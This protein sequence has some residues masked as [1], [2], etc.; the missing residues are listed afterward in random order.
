MI[1]QL[2]RLRVIAACG[3]AA[4]ACAS[5]L[6]AYFGADCGGLAFIGCWLL[7]VSALSLHPGRAQFIAAAALSA[8]FA[9]MRTLGASYDAIDSYG[10]ILK[11]ART[12]VTASLAMGALF[13]VAEEKGFGDEQLVDALFVAAGV[14][15]VIAQRACIS[16][17]QGGCQAEC[18]SASAMAAAALVQLAEGEKAA[19]D[20]AIAF[21]MMNLMGLVCDPVKGLVEVPCV[22]RNVIGVANALTAADMALAG[23][24]S[25]IPADE[26][27]DAMGRV[28][29]MLP[30]ALRETG[31][32]GCAAC[33]LRKD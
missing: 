29:A 17:A 6:G 22:Y 25:P 16:G 15:R 1:L 26:A 11:N 12:L 9:A 32:G 13:A 3:V 7:F 18:G 5:A 4:C 30:A 8:L 28:G 2:P 21:A 14:G 33:K 27:I 20:S 24:V 31:I 19:M 23:I 10:L